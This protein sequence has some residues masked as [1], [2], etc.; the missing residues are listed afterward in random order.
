MFQTIAPLILASGSPRRRKFLTDLGLVFTLAAAD[1]DETIHPGELPGELVCR[2]AGEKAA[3]VAAA[4]PE[5]W[6]IGADTVVVLGREILGKPSDPAEALAMLKRLAGRTHEVWTGVSLMR[7]SD[8]AS[9]TFAVCTEVTFAEASES[10]LAAYVATGEPLDKAGAYGIQG[11]GVF[12]VSAIAG[13]YS[14]VVGLPLPELLEQLLALGVID[15]AE[16]AA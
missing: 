3:A 8:R 5:A 4:H 10:V 9:R 11:H 7:R 6:V 2:L 16:P 12:L 14:N 15:P 1:L 13:S